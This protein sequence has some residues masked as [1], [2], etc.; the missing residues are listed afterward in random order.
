M[1]KRTKLSPENSSRLH[2]RYIRLPNR[3]LDVYDEL[4]YKS[5]RVIVAKSRITSEHSV[6]F[7]GE[8]VLAPGFQIIYFELMKKWFTVGKIRDL[9]GTHTGY[10]CDIVTPPRLLEDGG[11][12]LTDLFLD[13][14]VSP[15]LRYKVLDEEELENAFDEGWIARQLYERA[16][17]ELM[18]LI[19]I[20]KLGK[21]PP[22]H[23]KYLENKLRL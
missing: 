2:L 23:V 18:R 17:K 22:Y 12:E 10:Y 13:L 19:N 20:V 11:V 4:I 6:T 8:T 3:V 1:P 14:W 5:A 7:H 16:K 21:F 9:H 15:D